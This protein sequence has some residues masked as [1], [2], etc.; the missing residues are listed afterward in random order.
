MV[1]DS[2]KSSMLIEHPLIGSLYLLASMKGIA[3]LCFN[4]ADLNVCIIRLGEILG[5]DKVLDCMLSPPDFVIDAQEQIIEYLEG[6]RRKFNLP[7]DLSLTI[8]SFQRS[9]LAEVM[10]IPYGR[11]VTYGEI[12]LKVGGSSRS[13]GMA[14]AKNPLP[15]IIPCHRVVGRGGKLC[16]YGGGIP[17]KEALLRLEASRL[18]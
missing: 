8:S 10:S 2:Q 12:A 14:N 15:L 17:M 3:S 7:L 6:K 4:V 13:V 11:T 5:K 9:V 18:V 1:S 16:G